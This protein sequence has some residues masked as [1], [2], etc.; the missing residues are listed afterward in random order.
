MSSS[1][2]KS[3]AGFLSSP[4]DALYSGGERLAASSRSVSPVQSKI[5][6][7][8]AHGG[9][10]LLFCISVWAGRLTAVQQA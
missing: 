5:R 10:R 7:P 3:L 6:P 1:L 9:A 4:E 8:F 2:V